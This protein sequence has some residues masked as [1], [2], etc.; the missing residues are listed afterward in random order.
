MESILYNLVDGA[1]HSVIETLQLLY[2]AVLFGLM[3]W[4]LRSA[5]HRPDA[6]MLMSSLSVGLLLLL[7][8]REFSFGKY[9]DVPRGLRT[10]MRLTTFAGV[11]LLWAWTV[12][13]TGRQ[14]QQ[15]FREML[16][17]VWEIKVTFAVSVALGVFGFLV[18]KGV[19][20]VEPPELSLI[21]EEGTETVVYIILAWMLWSVT[22]RLRG[23]RRLAT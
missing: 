1:E 14:W 22:S 10:A 4:V 13:R 15:A 18:D 20:H 16:T 8:G 21:F 5:W 23:A 6:L 9:H 17:A 3:A 7:I 12:R 2:L 11:F 19:V